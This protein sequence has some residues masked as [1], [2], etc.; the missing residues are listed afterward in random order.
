ML[1]VR[2]GDRAADEVR[3]LW[4]LGFE[5]LVVVGLSSTRESS[6][7]AESR[8]NWR[9][10]LWDWLS[11]ARSRKVS[12][13]FTRNTRQSWIWGGQNWVEILKGRP[14]VFNSFGCSFLTLAISCCNGAESWLEKL[15]LCGHLGYWEDF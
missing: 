3:L 5:G 1:R 7:F 12:M 2:T 4:V 13:R 6:F 11:S 15:L 10:I 14:Y 8:I 9:A